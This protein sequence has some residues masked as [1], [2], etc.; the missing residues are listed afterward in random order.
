VLGLPVLAAVALPDGVTDELGVPD[1]LVVG[2]APSD[3]VDV[4]DDVLALEGVGVSAPDC[5]DVELAVLVLDTVLV[6]LAVPLADAPVL[7]DEV[8]VP[9]TLSDGVAVL[10]AVPDAVAVPEAV[11]VA[12]ALSVPLPVGLPLPVAV[13]VTLLLRL[14][15]GVTARPGTIIVEMSGHSSSPSARL[16]AALPVLIAS[17]AHMPPGPSERSMYG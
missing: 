2:T 4:I 13:G 16:P 8:G 7:P 14:R 5:V 10:L 12:V 1:G 15:V 3:S 9:A 11:A 6:P 17:T